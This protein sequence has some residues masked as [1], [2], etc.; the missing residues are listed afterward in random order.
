MILNTTHSQNCWWFWKKMRNCLHQ[1]WNIDKQKIF[2]QSFFEKTILEPLDKINMN[3][4]LT[5]N[6]L[7][8]KGCIDYVTAT[9]T[10]ICV[11]NETTESQTDASIEWYTQEKAQSEKDSHSKIR[12]GKY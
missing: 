2:D 5:T 3:D 10:D 8:C 12:G 7:Y 1:K 4:K 9:C 6:M 11:T